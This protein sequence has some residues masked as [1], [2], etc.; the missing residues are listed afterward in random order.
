MNTAHALRTNKCSAYTVQVELVVF[1][2]VW[3]YLLAGSPLKKKPQVLWSFLALCA[4][5]ICFVSVFTHR[6][7]QGG[8]RTIHCCWRKSR[9]GA[10]QSQKEEVSPIPVKNSF[11]PF[12]F[13]FINLLKNIYFYD[14]LTTTSVFNTCRKEDTKEADSEKEA[15]MEAELRAARERAIVPLEARMTQFKDMLLERGVTHPS[16]FKSLF[17]RTTWHE[18]FSLVDIFFPLHMLGNVKSFRIL[19]DTW[20]PFSFVV[21]FP[22][23]RCLHSQLGTKNSTRLFL[24]HVTYYWTQKKGNRL[25]F[26]FLTFS[27]HFSILYF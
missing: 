24:T 19:S 12:S 16:F 21:V 20:S 8:S 23:C 4:H 11:F 6:C 2:V 14:S 13:W 22:A 26:F 18:L 10:N 27:Q 15:A 17:E 5:Y 3:Y 9:W 25:F 7:Q 1:E